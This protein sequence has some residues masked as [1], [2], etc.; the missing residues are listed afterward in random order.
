MIMEEQVLKEL[1]EIKD[2]LAHLTGTHDLPKKDRFSKAAIAKAAKEYQK[3][4]MQRDDWIP[5][6]KFNKVFMETPRNCEK[7]LIEK[8][9]FTNYY[10]QGHGKIFNKTDLELLN[11][12]LKKKNINFKDYGE[13]L[14]DKEKFEKKINSIK[15]INSNKNHFKIPDNLENI[16]NTHPL[17]SIERVQNEIN[18]LLE[19]YNKFDLSEYIG[20]YDKQTYSMYKYDYSFDRYVDPQ[21]K[22]YCKDWCFKFNYANDA[23]LKK[24]R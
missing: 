1:K 3:L 21:K 20:L 7:V 24:N 22:K 14:L 18:E 11:K 19:D 10:K 4:A 15:F 17:P 2:L 16:N 12:E 5:R 9:K 13:L 8:F 23:L 6:W